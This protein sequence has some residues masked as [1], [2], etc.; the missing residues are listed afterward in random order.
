VPIDVVKILLERGANP[1][2][3]LKTPLLMRQH[4]GGDP[5]LGEGATP[6]MRASKVS[7]ATLMRV[8][9]EKGA[10]P[11]RRLRNQTT[12]VD[13]CGVSRGPECRS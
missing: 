2:A 10:D 1:N 4:N 6:L 7:D 11:N 9:L 5:S 8:L 13:D 3:A 12:A